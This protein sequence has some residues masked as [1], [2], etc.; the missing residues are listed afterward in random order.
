MSSTRESLHGLWSSRWVFILAA[1]GSAVGLG[2][3]WRFPYLT[4]ENGGGAFVML[5]L[6]CVLLVGIPIMIGETMIGRRGR[7]SPVNAML[8]IAEEENLT[9]RWAGLGLMGI[10][11]G[12]LTLSF[13][14]VVAGWSLAYVY[15]I[16]SNNFAAADA[17]TSQAIF[18]SLTRSPA[19]LLFWHTLFMVLVIWIVAKGVSLGLERAVKI[20]MPLLFAMLVFMVF[21][22]LIIGDALETA[23]YLFAVDFSSITSEIVLLAVGQAFFSLSLG[24]GALMIYG[25]YLPHDASI[26]QACLIVGFVD[27]LVALLAGFL[28]FPIVFAYGLEPEQGPGLVFVTLTVAFSDMPFGQLFGFFFFLL[29]TV[30]AWTSAISLLEPVVAWLVESKG[31]SRNRSSWFAGTL[32]WLLGT[33]SLLSFN[34]LKDF[35]PGGRTVFDWSE[36]ISANILLPLGGFLVA[37]FVGWR[38]SHMTTVS[39]FGYGDSIFYKSWL[40]LIK[41]CAPI[42][43]AIV[44]LNVSGLDFLFR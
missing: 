27:T 25:S 43:I 17:T 3:I 44:F 30:A 1:A 41:Y 37:I 10:V 39:E 21:Y 8:L 22:S 28:I 40:F 31:W 34:V 4:G 42:A 19:Q 2:N 35:T 13:Y 24:M 14:S 36:Y 20:L 9:R 12:F 16:L 7:R 11:A 29:L 32:I 18:S 6:G 15:F 26:P 23:K 33:L 5:Y 38:L